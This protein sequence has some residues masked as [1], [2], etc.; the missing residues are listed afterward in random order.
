[1]FVHKDCD[2]YIHRSKQIEIVK[3]H[4]FA[5]FSF[6]MSACLRYRTWSVL[7]QN[8][9]AVLASPD[10]KGF[11]MRRV[12]CHPNKYV[13]HSMAARLTTRSPNILVVF[14]LPDAEWRVARYSLRRKVTSLSRYCGPDKQRRMSPNSFSPHLVCQIDL[15]LIATGA[16]PIHAMQIIL[17]TRQQH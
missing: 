3:H 14:D 16:L 12:S 9:F 13:Y 1:M 11:A 4:K 17:S 10:K 7:C 6:A 8:I 2:S 15:S 5:E